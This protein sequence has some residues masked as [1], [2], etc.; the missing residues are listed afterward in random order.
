MTHTNSYHSMSRIT[1]ELTQ[2]SCVWSVCICDDVLITNDIPGGDTDEDDIKAGFD[3]WFD[4]ITWIENPLAKRKTTN[5]LFIFLRNHHVN[6]DWFISPSSP[7][8]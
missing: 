1:T 2:F 7:S 8:T 6:L 4:A 5:K 3:T